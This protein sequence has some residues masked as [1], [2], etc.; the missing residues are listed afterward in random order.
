MK[1]KE[2]TRRVRAAAVGAVRTLSGQSFYGYNDPRFLE[3][4]RNGGG[5]DTDPLC[6][7]AVLRCLS[8]ICGTIGTLPISLIEA[9]PQKR[10]AGEHPAHRLMKIK[11]NRWQTPLEFKRQMQLSFLRH[12]DAYARI[13]W[14][15][16]RPI[17]LI[18]LD[19]RSM[20][21]E[22]ADDLSLVYRYNTAKKGVLIL[23]QSEVFHLRDISPD[24]VTSLARMTLANEAIKL[25][26]Y[27]EE[28][29]RRIF[30]QGNMTDGF[31]QFP[32]ALKDEAYERLRKSLDKDYMGTQ[33]AGRLPILE[34]GGV[35]NPSSTTA[36]DA[37]HNEQRR[38]QIED[39]SRAFGVPRPLMMLDDTS[40][41]SGI[42][43]LG[44]YFLQYTMLEHFTNWEQA[45][46]RALLREEELE[47][48]QFKFNERALM[49]GTLKDQA[50]YYAKS[51]GAGGTKPWHSQN[52]I[53]E[54]EDYPRSDQP[55]TDDLTN[56][57]TQQG[58]G[59]EPKTTA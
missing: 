40:W 2:M 13:I 59:D 22:Q 55:G 11:P 5:N 1:L 45:A 17:E 30:E 58:Q 32:T 44:I 16:E 35:Y 25:A 4:L 31:L 56:P 50:D 57:M 42:E 48:Y 27:A 18:P 23:A 28:A 47:R 36:R 51:L 39:I 12:G 6:N 10:I 41:G 14:S 15:L 26:R 33:G 54:V 46:A 37:Q 52:E 38:M 29:A 19:S 49:R 21:V 7:T 20:H 53:R 8:L 3:F 24:G 34:E 9:G 43:Q